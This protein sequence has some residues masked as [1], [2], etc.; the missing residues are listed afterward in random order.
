MSFLWPISFLSLFAI[1]LLVLL[2]LRMQ[3]RRKQ[4]AVR[5]GS[6]GLVQQA[7]NGRALGSRRHLPALLFLLGLAILFFALARPQMSVSLPK[8]EGIVILAFDVSGSMSATDFEPTRMEAAKEVGREF[9][10]R[11]PS[12]VKV[13]IVS[14]SDNGFSMQLPTNDQEAILSSIDRLHPERGTSLANGIII[15]LNTIANATGQPPII[16]MDVPL[17]AS[18]SAPAPAP[19]SDA[20]DSAVIVLITDGENNMDPDPLQAAQFAAD[21]GVRI[22]TIGVGSSAGTV[23]EVNGFTVFT[24]LD[25][26]TLQQIAE[27]TDG[28]YYNAQTEEDLQV[29][30]ENID[31]QLVMVEEK[32]EVT[33]IFAGVSILILLVAGMISLLWFSHVP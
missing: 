8:V 16:G 9:V 21:R 10:K 22:H 18:S 31:P 23:L 25:E 13:G 26:A 7:A 32:T 29:I 24:Q 27:I 4:F 1:P 19:V 30:Y 28:N 11:Q 14:F 5:Y 17:D 6:L 15:S 33:A 3:N 12:T 20:G 2:Y